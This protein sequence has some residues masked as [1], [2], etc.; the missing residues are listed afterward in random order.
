MKYLA[1]NLKYLRTEFLLSQKKLGERINISASSIGCYEKERSTPSLRN[2]Q[3]LS[4]TFGVDIDTLLHVDLTTEHREISR[5]GKNIRVLPIVVESDN[6]EKASIVPAKAAAGYT[7]GYAEPQFVSSLVNFDL[8]FPELQKEQTYR[9]FQITGDSMLP[10]KNNSYVITSYLQNW[11]D[12]KFGSCYIVLTKEDGIVFKRIE[13]SESTHRLRMTSDNDQYD[14]Y[15]I[16][17]NDIKEIWV[18]KGIIDFDL[19]S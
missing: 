16:H 10:I 5:E 13:K 8:P 9:V 17:I 2:I 12:V 7:E 1:S 4:T 19:D 11:R 18:A 6:K 14:P 15:E 3:K